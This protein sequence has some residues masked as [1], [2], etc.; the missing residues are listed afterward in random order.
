MTATPEQTPDFRL[1]LRALRDPVPA[2]HRLKKAL[3]ILLRSFGLKCVACEPV[4]SNGPQ[5]SPA[6]PDAPG[7]APGTGKAVPA[8]DREPAVDAWSGEAPLGR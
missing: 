5:A 6:A 3:K 8:G 4:P 7:N 2:A 1:T